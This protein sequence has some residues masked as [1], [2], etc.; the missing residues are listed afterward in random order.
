[1]TKRKPMANAKISNNVNMKLTTSK[2]S[3]FLQPSCE[4][5]IRNLPTRNV[6]GVSNKRQIISLF[7]RICYTTGQIIDEV[8]KQSLLSVLSQLARRRERKIH[9][10][11]STVS[12]V[13]YQH[14]R[15]GQPR[16]QASG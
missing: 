3:F 9:V 10:S 8:K 14:I 12:N 6:S 1:M 2:N 16:P 4:S 15:Q 13:T 7:D 11:E 5:A